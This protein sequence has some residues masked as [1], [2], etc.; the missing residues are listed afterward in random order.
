MVQEPGQKHAGN[1]HEPASR[2]KSG[3]PP[4]ASYP[5][6][7]PEIGFIPSGQPLPLREAVRMLP[8][9]YRFILTKPGFESFLP[10]LSLAAWNIV[11]FQLLVYAVIAA[12]IG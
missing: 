1:G 7:S 2:K 3:R 12:E 4:R 11:W 5:A 6:W 8:R 9:R 10:E